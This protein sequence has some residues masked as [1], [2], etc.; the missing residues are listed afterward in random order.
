MEKK[1]FL[2]SLFDFS[3]M[4]FVT[5]TIIRILYGIALVLV[6]IVTLLWIVLGFDQGT[7]YGIFALFTSPLIFLLG[8]LIARVELELTMVIFA[9]KEDLGE[10]RRG[11]RHGSTEHSAIDQGE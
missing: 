7:G 9:M 2:G 10:I 5:P 4:D 3:F 11:T 1:G 8:A 6:G